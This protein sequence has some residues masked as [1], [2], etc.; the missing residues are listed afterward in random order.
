MRRSIKNEIKVEEEETPSIPCRSRTRLSGD[1]GCYIHAGAHRRSS[2]IRGKGYVCWCLILYLQGDDEKKRNNIIEIG[3]YSTAVVCVCMISDTSILPARWIC[4]R[5]MEYAVLC[6]WIVVAF[7]N[8]TNSGPREYPSGAS[9]RIGLER[10]FFLSLFFCS[11]YRES[12][13]WCCRLL[14]FFLFFLFLLQAPTRKRQ[15]PSPL[16]V[17]YK[18]SHHHRRHSPLNPRQ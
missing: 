5:D 3:P 2:S 18:R 9:S 6:T 17:Y 10:F 1:S 8:V 7:E 15:S 12:I 4:E 16:Y 11:L 14:A 13:L